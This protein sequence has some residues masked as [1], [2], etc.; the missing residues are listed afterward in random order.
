MYICV[1]GYTINVGS[2]HV[3]RVRVSNTH[4]RTVLISFYSTASSGLG[5][6]WWKVVFRPT[7]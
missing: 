6:F 4:R 2:V 7:N 1:F 3:L 5:L